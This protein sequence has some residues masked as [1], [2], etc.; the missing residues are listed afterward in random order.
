MQL[1]ADNLTLMRG[2]R[3][4]IDRLSFR[5][6]AGDTL[7][8]TGPNG[9]GK[10]TLIRA[11]AGLLRP[12]AGSIRL[13]GGA[14]AIEVAEQAHYVGHLNGIKPSLTVAEN[15]AFW[16]AYLD[17][18]GN[19]HDV[20]DALDRFGLASLAEIPAGYLSAG[21]KRRLGLARLLVARRPVWLLDEP[22][23][24]LDAAST[25]LLAEVVDSHVAAGGL[26]VAATHLPLGLAR[27]TELRLGALS[28][29]AGG[30][31]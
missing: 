15:L 20:A 26:V 16:R 30:E 25:R 3:T 27:T 2:A 10:T 5:A 18:S 14:A 29:Q 22:T 12:S 28:P 31:R 21:Q 11:L 6:A 7:L 24:S 17:G 9:A 23:V 13:D 4:V 1:I 8:L 19:P